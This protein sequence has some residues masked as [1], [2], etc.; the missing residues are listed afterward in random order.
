MDWMRIKLVAAAVVLVGL[1]AACGGSAATPVVP[2]GSAG[3]AGRA[4]GVV[5][6]TDGGSYRDITV[7]ELKT[8]LSAKDFFFVNTHI[9]YEG[10]IDKTDAFVPY[11]ALDENLGKL[12]SDKNAK[13]VLYCRSDN[14]STQAA[15]QLVKKGYTNLWNVRGGM[16]AWEQ[17]GLP[18]LHK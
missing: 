10:E 16:A 13:I 14:M 3:A 18:L 12:P 8:M 17:A 15:R 2:P 5:V 7:E 11:D 1:V 9:P 6:T 4:Q